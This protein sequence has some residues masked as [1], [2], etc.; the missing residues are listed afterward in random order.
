[1]GA[2]A[3]DGGL[4][5]GVKVVVKVVVRVMLTWGGREEVI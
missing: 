3:G 2:G 5:R 1:M 4:L